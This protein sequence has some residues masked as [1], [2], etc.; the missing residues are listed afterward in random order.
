MRPLPV[1]RLDPTTIDHQAWHGSAVII[2]VN[3][4][5]GVGK[6]TTAR[7]VASKSAQLRTFDPESVG[8]MLREN[9][10]DFPVTDFRDWESWRIL[11]PIVA[12]EVIRFSRQSLI[13]PQT[14]LEETYWD[15]ILHGLS[16]RGHHVFHVLLEADETTMRNRIEADQELAVARQGRLNHLPKFAHARSWMARRADLI[17][18]TTRLSPE[19]VADQVWDAA[20]DRVKE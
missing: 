13:A 19:Q 8:F 18:D 14:V 11:T 4:T 9:L 7:L 6:T 16:D 17:L 10:N 1:E 5:F 2:W 15:E 20:Q 3:G 12:D